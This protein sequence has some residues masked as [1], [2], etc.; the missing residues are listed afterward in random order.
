MKKKCVIFCNGNP[1]YYLMRFDRLPGIGNSP[2]WT[3]SIEKAMVFE[4]KATAKDYLNGYW[5]DNCRKRCE[6]K[7][8]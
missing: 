1:G 3:P 7:A 2:V 6:I 8:I 4:S 5:F